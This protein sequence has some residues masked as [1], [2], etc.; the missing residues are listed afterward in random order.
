MGDKDNTNSGPGEGFING[1]YV[2]IRHGSPLGDAL[3]PNDDGYG[4]LRNVKR[5]GSMLQDAAADKNVP[6][7]E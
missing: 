1:V 4:H 6:S 3:A 7:G 5:F 2:G